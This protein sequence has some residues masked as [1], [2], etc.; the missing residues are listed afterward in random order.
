MIN[1]KEEKNH[2]LPV[3][4]T[5]EHSTVFSLQLMQN[6]LELIKLELIIKSSA[7]ELIKMTSWIIKPDEY[8]PAWE[9]QQ[10]FL[11]LR[12]EW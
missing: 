3:S 2:L 1:Q 9:G 12:A 4:L 11:L 5:K 7:Y 6:K 10:L 8:F